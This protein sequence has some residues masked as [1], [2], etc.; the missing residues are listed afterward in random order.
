MN[1]VNRRI[2]LQSTTGRDSALP[3]LSLIS[4]QSSRGMTTDRMIGTR[5][6]HILVTGVLGQGGMGEVYRGT[7][8][9]LNRPVALKVIRADRRLSIDARGRFLREAR[10]LSSLDHPHICRIHEYIEAE[11]G[12][13][14]VLELIEGV[15]LEDAIAQGMSRA[16]KLRIA[17]EICDALAAAHRKGIVHRDLKEENV[18]IARDGSA[19]VLDFGI[20]RQFVEGEDDV[21]PAALPVEQ[22]VEE[23]ATLIFPVG[24][25]AVTPGIPRPVTEHGIAVG[26]P[27]WMSPEQA[28]GQKATAAS[29]MYSFGLILQTL[30]TEKPAHPM[31]LSS[32]ELM[33][34]AAAGT[35]DPMT[36][37]SRDVTALVDRLKRLAPADRPT[38]VETLEVLRR[39][40][41]APKRR[42]RLGALVVILLLL[43]AGAAKYVA[44]VT[45]ARREADRRRQQA[46]GLVAFIV[47]DLRTKLE[48]VGR[49]DVLDG[50]ASR[51]L[52]YFASLSPEELSGGDLHKN[53]LALAQLGEVRINEGKLD[54]AVKLFNESIRFASAAV[55]RDPKQEEWQ[56]ALSN[57][58]FWLGDAL[59]RK[60]DHAGTLE[61]FRTYLNIS[62]GLAARHPGDA[63]Y[64]AEV[65]YGHGNVGAAYEAAGNLDGALA[66]YQTAVDL[67]RKRLQREPGNEKWQTDLALSLNS[68]GVMLQTTGDLAGARKAFGEELTLR[69]QLFNAVPND[70]RRISGLAVSLAY[71]GGL[72]NLMG[73]TGQALQSTREELQ[74]ATLLATLDPANVNYRRNRIVAQVRASAF[75][76]N[77]VPAAL[78]LA[79]TGE[80][81]LRELVRVEPRP[82][83]RLDL[84]VAATRTASLLLLSEDRRGARVAAHD[85]LAIIEP[86]READPGNP[87]VLRFL[88]EALLMA[89][90]VEE[91]N[92]NGE[93]A[94]SHRARVAA[95][96]AVRSG[97]DLRFASI[98]ARALLG[99]GQHQ[100]ASPYAS[101]LFA[102][103]YRDAE[104]A[105]LSRTVPPTDPSP[106]P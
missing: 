37:Q 28:L 33:M 45:S 49:L 87:H 54:E 46:E 77:D 78:K 72:Q 43:A 81:E 97:S 70:A 106:I 18:M 20:A 52:A 9:R 94:H 50:A 63:K 15:T 51:A 61:H 71:I 98:H 17:L 58:H 80:A 44:D 12:D 100:Q 83:W 39:I 8:E 5:I 62:K 67:D 56:L 19:K 35:S 57:A 93:L 40:V 29:D 85:A 104:L 99:M 88:C 103:G 95:L 65:S 32:T 7:D 69:R 27:A 101:K 23:A 34:R 92:G 30:F 10:A 48:A 4:R 55:G 79:Q 105:P 2:G 14:L 22:P 3:H 41:D 59:R 21:E 82:T 96:T 42:A 84:G 91:Q 47:G 75:M 68:L 60:G 74:L 53:A 25:A 1:A 64:A 26:T 16:R 13:Y 76:T 73:E 66:E 89:A 90:K 36:G 102:A 31:Q 24:G 86:L 38:A 11:E 6:G